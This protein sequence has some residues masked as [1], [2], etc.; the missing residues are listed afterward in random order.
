MN[1]YENNKQLLTAIGGNADNYSTDFEVRKAILDALGGDSSKCYSIYDVDKQILNIYL[2]GGGGTGG[3]EKTKVFSLKVNNSCIVD[4]YWPAEN[5][6]TSNLNSMDSM[7]K[8]C[9]SLQTLDVSNWDTSNVTSMFSAF[10]N[11][12]SLQTLDVS[13]WD[14]SKVES[15]IDYM[16]YNCKTLKSLDVSNWDT[17]KVTSMKE[18]FYSC[19]SLQTLDVSNWDTSRVTSMIKM[20]CVCSSLQSLDVSNWDTSRVTDMYYMFSGCKTLQSLD[21]SNW[22]ASKVTNIGGL[23]NICG[24]N[25]GTF[26]AVG[27]RTIDE[28]ISGNI[29]ILNG[30]NVNILSNVTSE[31]SDRATLRAL[32][33]GV[34]D[35]TGQSSL[36][37]S[38]GTTNKAKLTEEDIAIATAKNWTIA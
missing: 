25:N 19:S 34:A 8:N 7:F 30:L 3:S 36:S 15:N 37:M 5:F 13:N 38:L 11:C 1:I 26:N 2:E 29:G 4:G 20:F 16:F 23:F 21:V 9:S 14:T 22:D 17:S 12:S 6:D 10:Y 28:I 27:G 32:I 33:N 35:R 31:Y 24:S 18:M